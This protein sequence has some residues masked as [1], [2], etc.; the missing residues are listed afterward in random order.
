MDI[1]STS[2]AVIVHLGE[3]ENSFGCTEEEKKTL[4]MTKK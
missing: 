2:K 4:Y 3:G 1:R